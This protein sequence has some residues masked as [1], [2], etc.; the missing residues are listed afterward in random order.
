MTGSAPINASGSATRLS[1]HRTPRSSLQLV[2]A[3]LY[4][5]QRRA[6]AFHTRA[7]G[8]RLAKQLSSWEQKNYRHPS[9]PSQYKMKDVASTAWSALVDEPRV[10]L[11]PWH[12]FRPGFLEF[13]RVSWR[14]RRH[15]S[16]SLPWIIKS[17]CWRIR[18][19]R[20]FSI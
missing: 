15:A 16:R 7:L 20:S 6:Y 17:L 10:F 11:I 2:T 14:V 3:S 5:L 1:L 12:A 13:W 19:L 18:T 9:R 4:V 8:R